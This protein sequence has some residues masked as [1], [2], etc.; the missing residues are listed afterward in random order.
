M[1]RKDWVL[2]LLLSYCACFF[3]ILRFVKIF[4]KIKIIFFNNRVRYV[5]GI[6][7]F[8]GHHFTALSGLGD[9][10]DRSTST[11]LGSAAWPDRMEYRFSPWGA[12]HPACR[13]ISL[14]L[15]S[16]AHSIHKIEPLPSH[17]S[18]CPDPTPSSAEPWNPHRALGLSPSCSEPQ[19]R[20]LWHTCSVHFTGK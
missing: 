8:M 6:V 19:C 4:P 14:Y 15:P 12:P 1:G 13:H 20:H 3:K 10:C 9:I 7:I 16:A 11:G 5:L 17:F 18:H 2:V